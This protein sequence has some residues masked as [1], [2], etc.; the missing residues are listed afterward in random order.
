LEGQEKLFLIRRYSCFS[1]LSCPS[2]QEW[3]RE[4]IYKN[5]KRKLKD[6][7][8]QSCAGSRRP[9]SL[10][11]NFK[12]EITRQIVFAG[13]PTNTLL[14]NLFFR[15]INLNKKSTTWQFVFWRYSEIETF[16]F[17]RNPRREIAWQFVFLDFSKLFDLLRIP[18]PC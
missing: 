7:S 13:N 14:G 3:A 4:N 5:G 12:Q 9:S 11:R 16:A 15:E 10:H 2:N 1:E 6:K 17:G 8:N 18:Q